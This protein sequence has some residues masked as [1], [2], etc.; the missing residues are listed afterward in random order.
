MEENSPAAKAGLKTGDVVLSLNGKAIKDARDLSRQVASLDPGATAAVQVWR[1]NAKRDLSVT[2]GRLG[3][4][5]A[6]SA[7][8]RSQTAE[9]GKLGLS[10]APSSDTARKGVAVVKVEPGSSAAEKG[11]KAGDVIAE[12]GGR[13]VE[14][15]DD[16]KAAV[17]SARQQG[18]KA[19]L[20][21]LEAKEG[22]RFV[23]VQV[24]AA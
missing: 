16:V 17:E 1:D 3:G 24:P 11:F 4:D 10:L 14:S 22:S 21:R 6:A 2:L 19:V 7:E 12:V 18:K 9:L 23:G 15:P 20:F 5:K 8:P 13:A